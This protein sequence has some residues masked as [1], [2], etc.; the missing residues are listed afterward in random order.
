M[1]F[2]LNGITPFI[3]VATCNEGTY[4][5]TNPKRVPHAG[6]SWLFHF[7]ISFTRMATAQKPCTIFSLFVAQQ[8]DCCLKLSTL[9]HTEAPEVIKRSQDIVEPIR[10]NRAKS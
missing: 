8:I 1:R 10:G 3:L 2:A 7:K 9:V 6:F 5:F 4:S